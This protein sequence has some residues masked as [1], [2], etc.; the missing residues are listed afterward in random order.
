MNELQCHYMTDKMLSRKC[1]TEEDTW[2]GYGSMY[3]MFK[4]RQ[5]QVKSTVPEATRAVFGKG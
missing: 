4:I 3:V 2:Y 5:N 1:N